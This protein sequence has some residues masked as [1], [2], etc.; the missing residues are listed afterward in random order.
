M[1]DR[2]YFP[3]LNSIR[4]FASISVV[5]IHIEQF[6]GF[7]GLNNQS[8]APFFLS[9]FVLNGRDAVTL[10]FVLS[11]FLITYLLL[12]E[13]QSTGNIAIR[14]FY[15]R[16]ALRIWPLYYMILLISFVVIPGIFHLTHFKGYY[17]SLSDRFFVK[18]GLMFF[19][20]PNIADLLN[21][22]VLGA[23]HLWTIG[24]EE[25]FYLIW[26]QLLKRCARWI[27]ACLL[28]V[29]FIKLGF[30]V[31]N[32]IWGDTPAPFGLPFLRAPFIFILNFRIESMAIGGL[33]A[34]ILFNQKTALLDFIFHPLTE[35]IILGLMIL[36]T[37][38][39][40]STGLLTDALLSVIYIAFILNISSNP[41]ST[42]KLEH[43]MLNRLGNY[44]YG[45]YMYHPAIIYITLV[46]C[47]L[48][49][50]TDATQPLFNPLLNLIIIFFTIGT[51]AF[52][53][54]WFEMPFLRFK[55]RLVVIRSGNELPQDRQLTLLE[56]PHAPQ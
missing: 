30:A 22:Y 14:K 36:N 42:I 47:I 48:L 19:F 55:N 18:L 6:K 54:H 11:G 20:L 13:L 3:G 17:I 1:Q 10:F 16:R 31:L 5:I 12:A 21:I 24:V 9:D 45:I 51:A 49:G 43:P 34:Y 39:M 7:L 56:N 28:G 26:P 41:H 29:V 53:Y 46:F 8:N 44:S 52:S 25:Q 40:R 15:L 37:T 33:G 32:A 2:V 38:V 23:M 27:L 35:K 50:L 4:F